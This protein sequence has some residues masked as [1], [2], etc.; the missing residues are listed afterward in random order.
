MKK[1]FVVAGTTLAGVAVVPFS[2]VMATLY[3]K[4]GILN[5]GYAVF[6]TVIC[7]AVG[8]GIGIYLVTKK[9]GGKMKQRL[10]ACVAGAIV[11]FGIV[12]LVLLLYNIYGGHGQIS[13][14]FCAIATVVLGISGL[15]LGGTFPYEEQEGK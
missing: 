8:A 12:P 9:A 7:I 1:F 5:V 3:E 10:L 4:W 13:A 2:I 15:L 11:G 14:G 6:I